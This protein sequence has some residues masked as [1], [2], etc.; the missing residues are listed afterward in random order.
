MLKLSTTAL[1]S[2]AFFAENQLDTRPSAFL[3]TK[4]LTTTF[5]STCAGIL[6]TVAPLK[7]MRPILKSEPWLNET[8]RAARR[9][10]RRAERR[11]KKDKLHVSFEILKESWKKYQRTVKAEKTVYFSDIISQ[12]L[13]KPRALFKT[14][15]SILNAPQSTCLGASSQVCENFLLFYL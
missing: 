8:T 5:L 6:D 2:S 9:E 3:D 12:N 1:F 15:D 11:W 14:V 10:C 7:R 4:Q 13:N